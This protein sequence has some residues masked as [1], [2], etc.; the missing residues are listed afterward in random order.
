MIEPPIAFLPCVGSL[1]PE[2][3]AKVFTYERMRVYTS[4]IMRIFGTEQSRSS[5]RRVQFATRSGSNQLM[6]Q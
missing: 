5:K 4:R 2:L 3:L 1:N 6:T